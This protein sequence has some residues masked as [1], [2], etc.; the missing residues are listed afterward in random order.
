MDD[1]ASIVETLRAK[2]KP[3][4]LAGMAR[5][6]MAVDRRLGVSIPELRKLARRIG[7]D[8]RIALALWQEGLAET[9]ILAS[10]VGEPDRLTGETMDLWAEDFDSWD[11]CDQVCM[12]LFDKSF[13]AWE[14]VREWSIRREEF[15]K[16]AAFALIA[17]L[18]WHD[19]EAEDV[20]FLELLPVIEAGAEDERN[21]VKKAVSWALRH[22]GKRNAKLNAPA[23][24]LADRL[25]QS[26]AKPAR[27]IGSDAY[28]ELTGEAVQRRLKTGSS[29]Q[30]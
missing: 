28:R 22:I 25:R 1:V 30:A 14:K 12:N 9:R 2:A 21:Y 23:I 20:R 5:Y 16:R 18:A 10:M 15:V 24:A 13:L 3:E 7:K 8:H 29:R 19:R 6:G 17:C 27:W 11:V 4:N 26:D